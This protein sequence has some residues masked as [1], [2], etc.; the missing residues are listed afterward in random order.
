[1]TNT[2]EYKQHDATIVKTVMQ[3]NTEVD[4]KFAQTWNYDNSSGSAKKYEQ[5][6]AAEENRFKNYPVKVRRFVQYNYKP[7][8]VFAVTRKILVLGSP[9]SKLEH[10]TQVNI[11]HA[12]L[13]QELRRGGEQVRGV[14]HQGGHQVHLDEGPQP[15]L[16]CP[17]RAAVLGELLYPSTHKYLPRPLERAPYPSHT[18]PQPGE[19]HRGVP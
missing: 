11:S 10:S 15:V 12:K 16:V 2:V 18:H 14:L 3:Y 8:I 7:N 19:D 1:M 13:V 5:T 4:T 6:F 17:I 9:L